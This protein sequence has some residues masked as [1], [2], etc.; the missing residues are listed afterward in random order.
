MLH[1]ATVGVKYFPGVKKS[2]FSPHFKNEAKILDPCNHLKSG[3]KIQLFASYP[4]FYIK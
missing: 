1:I 3:V 2:Y 4:T